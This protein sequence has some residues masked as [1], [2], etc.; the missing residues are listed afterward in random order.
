[1]NLIEWLENPAYSEFIPALTT[2]LKNAAWPEIEDA[3]Y[4]HVM[5][6]TGGIRGP[7]GIGPNRINSRTI[8]E[9]A[10]GLCFFINEYGQSAKSNGVVVGHEARRES[11]AFAELSCEIFAAN[12]IN[13][14]LFNSMRSTPEISFAV[15]HLE[16]TA[17]VQITA[18]HNP[19]TDNG[20]KF[21]WSDGGQVVA[22]LDN[23]FMNL[24]NGVEKIDRLPLKT[25]R[26]RGFV[27][28]VGEEVDREYIDNVRS[29]S[30]SQS[31]SAIIV[32]SPIHGAG[33]T[34]VTPVLREEQ[35][36]V[37]DVN[38]QKEPDETFPTAPGDLINPEYKEVMEQPVQLAE[39]IGA[40]VA[41]CSDPDADRIGVAAKKDLE[42]NK[43]EILTGNQVGAALI[44]FILTERKRANRLPKNGL[45]LE[46]LV[47]TN[48]ISDIAKSFDVNVKSDL[49][50][51]FKFIA[52]T[53]G[54][55]AN[56]DDFIFAAEES[57][58]YLTGNFVRDKDASIG[59]LL[60]SEMVSSL[61]DDGK[62]VSQYLD[63]LYEKYGYY[64]NAQ[65][66]IELPGKLGRQTMT[67]IMMNLRKNPPKNLGGLSIIG[68]KDLLGVANLSPESYSIG[69]S[70]DIISFELLDDSRSRI[71]IR[72][73]GTEP[74]LKIYIQRYEP[75][76]AS[77]QQTKR[78]ID[79]NVNNIIQ[80]ISSYLLEGLS[81]EL[82]PSWNTSLKRI[83]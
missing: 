45:V 33:S 16:A 27:Q 2:L 8:G 72:P 35:F 26:E 1:M 19:R 15:R 46:T 76:L 40:D 44:H 50:V 56:K 41:I 34:N 9:A 42:S 49:L 29:V 54:E 22:P 57:L 80:D 37:T 73:S 68:V 23:Q 31:R 12:G 39:Q 70:N 36:N 61:K 32:F 48:L 77:L 6:G 81:L 4:M 10:Q 21:Y 67:E 30:V 65:L 79:D 58:G 13:S 63:E 75:V 83:I 78:I 14:Y 55:M 38:T 43:L 3:F 20:F 71:T 17:G 74:K 18:S 25:A 51:G 82:M 53:I 7:L 24:V 66:L 47:T 69:G 64:K 59:A 5:I 60:T 28:T 62:T 52:K 11:R